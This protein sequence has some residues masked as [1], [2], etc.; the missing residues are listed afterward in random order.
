M[1][2]VAIEEITAGADVGVGSFYNHFS[3]KE[4]I[5]LAVMDKFF[6][7][8]GDA[9]DQL[10]TNIDDPAEIV[11]ISVRQTLLRVRHEPLWGQFLLREG[12]SERIFA[13]G[14]G[15]RLFRD[16]ERGL[17][18]GRFKSS[19]PLMTFV[20]AGGAVLGAI[21]LTLNQKTLDTA[22][23]KQLSLVAGEI[24]ER[25]VAVLLQALGLTP[26]EAKKISR[27]PLPKITS[28]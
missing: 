3:S 20:A 1:D 14:L 8:F 26:A 21:A 18:A 7:E 24:P 9:L 23:R 12:F 6:E 17:Q 27:R 16:I 15:V 25:T 13:R 19:D 5:Y 28:A 2:S 10:V 22:M 4:A 11:G